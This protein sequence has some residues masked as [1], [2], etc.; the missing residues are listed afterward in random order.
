MAWNGSSWVGSSSFNTA[1]TRSQINSLTASEYNALS[2]STGQD[3]WVRAYL[4]STGTS[5]CGVDNIEV[6]GQ[7]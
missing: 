4:T 6:K 7:R 5:A 3:L 2:S 1:S